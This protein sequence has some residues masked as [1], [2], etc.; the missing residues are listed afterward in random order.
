MEGQ[1]CLQG[2]G[3]KK[4]TA[5]CCSAP[6]SFLARRR[7]QWLQVGVIQGSILPILPW[8]WGVALCT[9]RASPPAPRSMGSAAS[10]GCR[11]PCCCVVLSDALPAS[12]DRLNAF[13]NFSHS[14]S[15]PFYSLLP[16]KE[17]ILPNPLELE[18]KGSTLDLCR[19]SSGC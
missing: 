8:V 5:V 3:A 17:G 15:S 2:F 4:F 16:R 11:A 1:V 6:S 19:E 14:A 10:K 13:V 7:N 9:P 18:R 12:C